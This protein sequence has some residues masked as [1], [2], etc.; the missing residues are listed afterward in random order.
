MN[1]LF[2]IRLLHNEPLNKGKMFLFVSSFLK[3]R[4]I[5]VWLL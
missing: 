3:A 4:T 2:S 5:F 1:N